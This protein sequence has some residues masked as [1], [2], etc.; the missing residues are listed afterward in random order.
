MST[1]GNVY[2]KISDHLETNVP[3]LIYIDKDR[4]QTE[5]E[6]IVLVPKPAVLIGFQRFEW[7]AIGGGV[8]QGK[9]SIRIRVVCENYAES[10]SGSIDQD[11]ALAFF[12][13][14]EEIDNALEGLSG[15][16][17]SQ[18][19]KISDEDDLDHDNVIITVYEYETTITDYSKAECQNMVPVD[20][21]PI[22]KYVN[23]KDLPKKQVSDDIG[24]IINI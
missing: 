2:K 22:V 6:N 20:A 3:Q 8:R 4:G 18:L 15:E 13:L 5:K 9:G 10:Y 7:E 23:K 11:Q 12:D 14:N 19:T 24:F 17:F 21:E 1:K 16:S